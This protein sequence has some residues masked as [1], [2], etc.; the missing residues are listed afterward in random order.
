MFWMN[1]LFFLFRPLFS[2]LSFFLDIFWTFFLLC[3]FFLSFLSFPLYFLLSFNIFIPFSFS[4]CYFLS[5]FLSFLYFSC[6]LFMSFSK[7][8][9]NFIYSFLSLILFI[10]WNRREYLKTNNNFY[11][12]PI[13]YD[14]YYFLSIKEDLASKPCNFL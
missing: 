7:L 11:Y 6:I 4:I 2:F 1:F 8:K 5:Y 3:F 10:H 14:F 13:I 12:L 9:I